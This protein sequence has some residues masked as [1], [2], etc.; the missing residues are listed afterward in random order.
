MTGMANHPIYSDPYELFRSVV[1]Q[2]KDQQGP[3]LH[4]TNFMEQ[5]ILVPVNRNGHRQAV[6]M[7]GPTTHQK[8]NDP[9]CTTLLN[10]YGIPNEERSKWLVYWR[11]LPFMNR[12]QFLHICVSTNWMI[13]QEVLE[14]TDVFQSSLKYG[15]AHQQKENELALAERREFSIFHEGMEDANHMMALISN[16]DKT[17]L[18]RMLANV[19]NDTSHTEGQSKRSYIRSI[20]NL[21]IG[22]IALSSHA[23]VEGG[24]NEELASTLSE[25]HIQHIEEL[26]ELAL[27]QAAAFG[28]IVDFVDRVDQVRKNRSSKPVQI[29]KEYIYL[30]LF[31]EIPLQQLAVL[32]GLNASYLSQLFKKETGLSLTNYIQKERIE[33]SKKLL[34]HTNDSIS[35][36]CARLTFY[37]QA[38]FVKV[39][40]K[41]AGV[42]PKQ[43]RNRS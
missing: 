11:N 27:I 14:I 2:E 31:E 43:Y 13:N 24:L 18:M 39:F 5:F 20:K 35:T 22:G 29:C 36:I 17:E 23:A 25:L 33:E 19:T 28:A 3:V 41:H 26:N 34:D 12:L 15:V 8:L 37:D 1:R 42:T 10:D 32:S 6:I 7:I 9:L 38:H 16:G 30:H 40:K 4:E 21:A